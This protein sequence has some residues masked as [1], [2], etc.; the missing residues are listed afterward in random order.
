MATQRINDQISAPVVRLIDG[1]GKMLGE[2]A[3]DQA[4][5]LAHDEGLDLIIVD[6]TASPPVAKLVDYGKYSYQ[7]AKRLKGGGK[8][9]RSEIKEVRLSARIDKHDFEIKANRA[10]MFLKEGDKVL[11]R[12]RMRGR[13]QIFSENVKEMLYRF[14]IAVGAKFESPPKRLGNSWQAIIIKS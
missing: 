7:E 12:V 6:A 1:S 10:K 2:I 11:V 5:L 13:E 8:G 4:L 14:E 9:K 3:R